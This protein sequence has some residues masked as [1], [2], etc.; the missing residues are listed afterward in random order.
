[1][2]LQFRILAL[3]A[4]GM[5]L[6]NSIPQHFSVHPPQIPDYPNLSDFADQIRKAEEPAAPFCSLRY[7]ENDQQLYR[8]GLAVGQKYAGCCV[9]NNS[10]MISTDGE[11]DLTP[12]QASEQIGCEIS[13]TDGEMTVQLPFQ[14]ARLI[15][16]SMQQPELYG[17]RLIA[18]GYRDLY[19]IQ[20]DSQQEAYQ[21]YQAYQPIA[22]PG[23][24]GLQFHFCECIL[25]PVS[26]T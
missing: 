12:Q 21:A 4:A 10:L 8:D 26:A 24:R 15:V 2:K 1:M 16:K 13:E 11:N 19:V 9:Q 5:L 22:G 7:S 14:T 20:Y 25:T 3:A 18:S 23:P 6:T 17:G